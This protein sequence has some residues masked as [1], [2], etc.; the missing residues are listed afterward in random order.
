MEAVQNCDVGASQGPLDIKRFVIECVNNIRKIY[1]FCEDTFQN[2]KQ[3]GGGRMKVV[4][5]LFSLSFGGNNNERLPI[6]VVMVVTPCC[7]V[8]GY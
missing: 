7:R 6:V 4:C 3:H 1:H 5:G 2:V 8:G